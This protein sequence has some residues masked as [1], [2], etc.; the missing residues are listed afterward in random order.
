MHYM[1]LSHLPTLIVDKLKHAFKFL[2][3]EHLMRERDLKRQEKQ[4]KPR[5]DNEPDT[6]PDEKK[7]SIRP[8]RR[9]KFPRSSN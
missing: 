8:I 4:E 6:K 9:I 1:M 2:P 3:A 7:D 5:D